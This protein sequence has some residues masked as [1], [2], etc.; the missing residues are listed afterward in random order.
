MPLSS[1]SR[2][3]PYEILSPLGS[4]G[5][6]EVYRARDSKLK[7]EV[8]V[9][10]LPPSLARDP[11]A[12][13][14][15]EREALAVAAL[16]HPN[17]LSIFDFGTQDGTTYAVMELLKGDTLRGKLDAGP[18]PQKQAV[19]YSVQIARGLSAAHGKGVVH[20][21]LKPENVFVS[22]DGHVK[23]LD[24]GLAKR[25]DKTDPDELT[26]APTNSGRTG[27]GTV[28]GTMGYMSPEQVRGLPVDH[29]TDIFSFGAILYE[30]L[31]G[32]KAFKRNTASDTI[33]AILKE[34]PPELSQSGAHISPSLDHIVRHCLEKD[35]E[36][37]FQTAKDVAFALSEAS[38]ALAPGE[39]ALAAPHKKAP[40]LAAAAPARLFVGILAA[41]GLFLIILLWRGRSPA[42]PPSGD[43][44]RERR[45]IA[46]LP[47]Q[48][49]SPDPENAFFA[50]GMT[51]D[52]LTQLAKIRDLKV[53][54]RTSVMRYK[55]TTKPLQT[56]AAELGVGTVL[57]GSVR[58][59][60]NRVRIV[61]QL[62]DVRTDEHLWAET[63]DRD[64]KDVFA[65]QG[66]VAERIAG[67]LRAALSP[68]EKR[69]IAQKPTGSLEAYDDYLKGREFYYRYRKEDN[70]A[71]IGLFKKALDLDPNFSL[72]YAGLGDGH[73][74]RALRFGFP[75]SEFQASEVAARKAIAL[76]PELADGHKAL[77][78]VQYSKGA[79]PES[80]A[81]YKRAIQINPSYAV[82]IS[83]VCLALRNMGRLDEALPS[84]LRAVALDPTN[85]VFATG[86]G[87]TYEMLGELKQ[88]E[89]WF[90]R[91]LELQKDL[92]QGHAYL[93]AF[94]LRQNRD[95][96][97]LRQA[98]ESASLFPN[99][100]WIAHAGAVA[101]LLTGHTTPAQKLFEGV[102]TPF[103]GVRTGSRTT[104]A[105]VETH[106][107]Y[108]DV[109]AGKRYEA[110]SLL[111]ESLAVDR[112][113]AEQG[114]RDWSVPFDTACVHALHGNKDEAFRWLEKAVD[115][116]WLGWPLGTREP[117]LDSLRAD[118][119]FKR[120][121]A[122]VAGMLA[123]VRRRA[124]AAAAKSAS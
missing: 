46:V 24:F 41:A 13:A 69:R 116:G 110:E 54:S 80:L 114:N 9:K 48:N 22:R 85:P 17:I 92:G 10:V 43:S 75:Q 42:A 94:Y 60:G 52:I 77:G 37:R 82:A 106:L 27:P 53:I 124:S 51:E 18:V 3:G 7:R 44:S 93:I 99:D 28:M 58:R 108:L 66:E 112:R 98:R 68:A 38:D 39:H 88:A 49:L 23:I 97:A 74:Q 71:A 15:F 57:E 62:I 122:R 4:G 96:D 19:D 84:C 33:A 64:L 29:R 86:L 8:A 76:N 40:L 67:A 61:G 26:S 50:D 87:S 102:R 117:A 101:E 30:L 72:A 73:A 11:D 45:S 90:K 78:L 119:R 21:D 12:L 36:N 79:Y 103:K 100:S 6:G 123:D 107:A 32:A 47:F 35:R 63:Y 2:L 1:G 95:A 113:E 25:L 59:S 20:R 34:E 16:S 115:A 121:E 65:I 56:V 118:A 55:G 109:V 31:S 104:G 89:H 111:D 70:E 14:R 81:A 105:G 120:L 91:C 83:T 5:M